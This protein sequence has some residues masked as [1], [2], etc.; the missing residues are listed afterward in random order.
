MAQFDIDAAV[1]EAIKAIGP[2]PGQ[3][4]GREPKQKYA[5]SLSSALAVALATALRD[6]GL[7]GCRPAGPGEIGTS[8]AEKRMAGGIGAKKVDV[9]WSTDESGLIL[10]L[11]IKTINFADGKTHNYQKNLTNRRGDMLFESVTLHRR[12]PY[13]VI[14][15]FLFLDWG[16]GQDGT[17]QR[18][19]TLKNA[20]QHFRL[21]TGR[22]DP[23]AREEQLEKV[24]I[25]TY[26]ANQFLPRTEVHEAGRLDEPPISFQ[27][28]VQQLLEL[29][30][31]RNT[32]L[33]ELR[34][35]KIRKT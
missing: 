22:V 25:V 8:G 9:C 32:D 15:G 4:V 30:A 11:S 33:Y 34:G 26:D 12:F 23:Y 5:Q 6:C 35:D 31:E 3:T 18:D 13:A 24:F 28:A 10:A 14:G 1:A 27:L 19:S 7:E 29:V 21:F 16:A 2:K 20:H 17:T